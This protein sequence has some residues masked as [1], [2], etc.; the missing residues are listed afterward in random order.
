[1]LLKIWKHIYD[2]IEMVLQWNIE[3]KSI[4]I[5]FIQSTLHKNVYGVLIELF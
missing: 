4:K 3:N 1:M 2:V 5:K